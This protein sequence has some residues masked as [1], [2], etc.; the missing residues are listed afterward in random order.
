MNR[1]LSLGIIGVFLIMAMA[2]IPGACAED[3][4]P[5]LEKALNMSHV[6]IYPSATFSTSDKRD[7]YVAIWFETQ[8]AAEKVMQWYEERL[9]GWQ[10]LSFKGR[11]ILYKGPN[12]LKATQ[13]FTRPYPYLFTQERGEGANRE[14]NI[15]IVVQQVISNAGG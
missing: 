4:P 7:T 11:T 15:T 8:D 9:T 14:T 1:Y 10:H 5:A 2:E 13:V 3:M 6:P 12:D